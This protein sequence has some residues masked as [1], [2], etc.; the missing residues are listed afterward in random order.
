MK[1]SK[2]FLRK[3]ELLMFDKELA[4]YNQ[5]GFCKIESFF[6][7]DEIANFENELKKFVEAYSKQLKWDE[8]NYAKDGVINSIHRL[9]GIGAIPDTF[10]S[11]LLSSSRMMNL[12]KTFLNDDA[13][14]RRME[15]FAKPAKVGMKSPWHQD[16]FYWCIKNANAITIWAALDYCGIENGG[17]EYYKGSHK[18]GL[19]DH[20]DSFAPGSSQTIADKAMLE[21]KKDQIVCLN[22]KPGDLMIHHSLTIHGSKDNLSD[23]ARRGLTFQYK[24]INAHYDPEMQKHYQDRLNF[25][26]GLRQKS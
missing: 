2:T 24:G 21:Q 23:R 17:V 16:N 6:S 12:A 15:L 3:M 18:W 7:I 11:R 10:F 8:I 9:A 20:T 13:D 1:P 26:V 14:P 22:L 5:N 19:L 25:Q 4:E